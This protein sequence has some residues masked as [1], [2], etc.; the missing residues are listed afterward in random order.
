MT[1][2]LFIKLLRDIRTI[3]PRI[4]LMIL[5]LS[6][7]LVMFSAVLYTWGVTGREMSRAYLSTN[8]A[9]ATLLFDRGLDADQMATIAA[10]T[11]QQPGIIDATSRTQ[12]TLQVQQEG[13]GWGPNPLQIFVAT[14]NDPMRI[15]SFMVEQ[16]SWPPAAGEILIDRSSFDLLN[17]EVGDAVVVQA[18][19]GEP[20]SL[21]ISGVVYDPALAPSFQEQKGHGFMSAASLPVLGEPIALDALKIQVADQPGLTTP[22]RNREVIVA[23][24]RDLAGWLQQTYGPAV[25][26]IQVPTPYA[27][28]HQ[29]QADSLLL[30]LLVF[31]VAG[32]LLSA[33]LIATMLNGLFAQQI[34]Q[35]GMMKAIGARSSRVLQLY[36]LMTLVIAAAS[37]TLAIVPGILISRAFAPVILTLLGVDAESLTAPAWMYGVVVAAG[38]GVPLLFSLASL[39]KASRTTV[40]EALDYHGVNR[41][42]DIPLRFASGTIIA[43]RFDAGLGRLPG[44]DRTMLMAFRNIFRR[45]ARFLLSVGLLASAGAVFIAGMSTMASI[46]TSLERDRALR[47]W[48]VEVRLA[49]IDQVS[50]EALTNLVADLPGVTRVEA[51]ST[52][53]TSVIPPGQQFSVTR[54]YPDQGHGSIG[55][56][57]IPPNSSLI[58]PPPLLKGRWLRPNET[59]AVVIS[60]A[61]LTQELP[62]VRSGDTIQLSLGGRPTSWLVVGVAESVGGHGGGIFITE[63]G[64]EAAAGASVSQPNL[65]RIVTNNHDEE[66]RTTVAQA[67]ERVLTDAGIVVRAAES[68]SRSAAASAGHML[69]LILVFLGLSIAIS[70]VG[71]AGLA[72]TMSTNVLE[73]TREFGVMSAIGAPAATVRRLVVLEGIFIA[74]VSCVIA[75]IPA[76]LLTAVM[77]EYM[78]MPVDLA[79][80]ISTL[81]VVIWV[82]M[83]VLGA[84]LATLAPASRASRLTV[85]EALA[86][87]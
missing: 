4:V 27:H 61:G 34:P 13:G 32:L 19:N 40:R 37:T 29:G 38:V 2:L 17:L 51:W 21:R 42:G 30:G 7:T 75:A 71:F 69:P 47:R 12:Y 73:R 59:D 76:F 72:S 43:T 9:S 31:G 86:Y 44:L 64:F 65:L 63:A 74:V 16:G 20:P 33:I 87:L 10:E 22:S 60:Q 39:V 85:R 53:Q 56:I 55:V 81:G 23:T 11:R 15:E 70:V 57:A 78:P 84:T 35:I 8:P 24:A 28:P 3:W 45:R 48:D 41:R 68:V 46:Q 79:F 52:L 5:A 82:V 1:P 50:A 66:T 77:I 6:I 14:P 58:T 36:L 54:T 26:E 83:V 18:P 49:D 67:A 62:D 80:Q 25:R